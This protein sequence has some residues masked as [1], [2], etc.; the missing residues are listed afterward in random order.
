VQGKAVQR[1]IT[2]AFPWQ[3]RLGD[4][5]TMSRYTTLYCSFFPRVIRVNM[6]YYQ[7]RL[8]IHCKQINKFSFCI[9]EKYIPILMF[10]PCIIRLAKTTDTWTE[11]YHSFIQC[12]GSYIFRQW[13]AII[14]ELHG[15]LEMQIEYVIYHIMFIYV[16]PSWVHALS[17]EAQ[18]TEPQHSG[19][20]AT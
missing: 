14:R 16:L 5:A 7:H 20:Q 17:W 8:Y 9:F 3:Q 4:R 15:L 6:V 2:V 10:V 1:E 18:Q 11:L 13:S 19:I 12:T